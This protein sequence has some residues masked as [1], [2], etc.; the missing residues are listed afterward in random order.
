MWIFI[1]LNMYAMKI[2]FIINLIK[3][4]RHEKDW[5]IFI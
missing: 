2:Y 3:L 1:T 4:V 5:Y